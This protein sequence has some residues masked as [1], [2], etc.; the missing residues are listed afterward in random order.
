MV[1]VAEECLAD[2]T[3]RKN[4]EFDNYIFKAPL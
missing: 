1:E 2:V 4:E 3:A